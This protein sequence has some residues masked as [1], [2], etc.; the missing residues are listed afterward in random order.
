M[1]I[2]F[3]VTNFRSIRDETTLSLYAE[4]PGTHLRENIAYPMKDSKIGVL[5]SLGL[6]GA[7]ASGKS[8]LLL[9]FE[10]LQYIISQT[11]SFKDGDLIRCYE[12]FRLSE[13]TKKAPV[14]FEVEFVTP[15]RSRY[16]YKVGFT[17]RKIVEETL[18]A[19]PSRQPAVLFS[20]KESDTWES[21]KFGTTYKGGKKRLPFF[22][23]NAYLSKAGNSA[24]A[25]ES[26]RAIFNYLRSDVIRVT[27]DSSIFVR[28]WAEEEHIIQQV[29]TL[30]SFADTG[31]DAIIVKERDTDSLILPDGMPDDLKEAF[32]RRKR[33]RF[34]FSHKTEEGE[35]EHFE[36]DEE[37]AG[38]RR[39]FELAPVLLDA[40]ASGG[41]VLLDE[42]E[43]SMHPLMAEFI[44]KL[45]NDREVNTKGAQLIFTT[46]NVH[47]MSS[48]YLRR[49]QIWFT[50]KKDGASQYFSLADFDKNIVKP[51]SPFNRWYLEG[52]FDAIPRI[53]YR[54]VVDLLSTSRDSNAQKK[55]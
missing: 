7:N 43:S 52:R 18:I 3:T 32:L 35:V 31:I 29:S 23:N 37:S 39:L 17:Q 15:D 38:T 9:A 54:K 45:F 48:E 25:P 12:P 27:H 13:S 5:K 50:E 10:A 36:L 24:D 11:G 19:Y 22:P 33:W 16:R 47:I 2:D 34:L 6:Y 21:I 8:N 30:L 41:V 46:H 28:G 53:D 4:H 20:R 44:L 55:Q 42:L 49:D 51:K 26:I 40:L 1:I 14:Y